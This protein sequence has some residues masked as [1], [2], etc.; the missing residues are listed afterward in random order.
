MLVYFA[1]CCCFKLTHSPSLASQ[2]GRTQCKSVTPCNSSSYESTPATATTDRTCSLCTS[3]STC[4]V[5]TFLNGTCAL[6]FNPQCA[7]CAAVGGFQDQVRLCS[8]ESFHF[9]CHV[10]FQLIKHP[11]HPTCRLA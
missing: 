10:I 4:G 5:G 11:P 2:A 9:F 3:A 6:R 7:S 1:H 8:F